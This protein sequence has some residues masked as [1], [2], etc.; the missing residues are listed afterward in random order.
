VCID[1][2][3]FL[4]DKIKEIDAE[5]QRQAEADKELERVYRSAPGIGP[6]HARIL[7]NELEDMKHFPN[8][9]ELFSF[10]GL[11]PCEYSS[12]GT[13]ALRAYQSARTFNIKE[14]VSSGGLESDL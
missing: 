5:L 11:T 4:N 13:Q 2:W 12:G 10:T 8:E 3:R 14:S 6:V 7:A 1:K 9:N